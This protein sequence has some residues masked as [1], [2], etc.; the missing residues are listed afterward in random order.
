MTDR[1]PYTYTVLRYVHDVTTGEFINVGL[2]VASLEQG[3]LR[4]RFNKSYGRLKCA[5]PTLNGET[6]RTRIRALQTSFDELSEQLGDR[7]RFEKDERNL[8]GVVRTLLPSDDSA[9]QWAP[10]GAGLSKDLPQTLDSL[11][12]RFVTKYDAPHAS[13]ER[14]KDDDVWRKFR[15]ELEKRHLSDFLTR[16]EIKAVDDSVAFEHAWKNG[17]WH[18]YEPVSFDLTNAAHIKDKALKW[19]GQLNSIQSAADEFKVYFLVGRPSE[20]SLAEAYERAIKLL[21]K[22]PESQVVEEDN[23]EEFSSHVAAKIE[24]HLNLRPLHLQ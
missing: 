12:S 3:Y 10:L 15:R 24:E 17:S 4:A 8:L 1:T 23:L 14:R 11:Y 13:I 21:K 19:L 9:L 2:V 16:K 18:C 6:F 5:F 20:P 7:L 22:A